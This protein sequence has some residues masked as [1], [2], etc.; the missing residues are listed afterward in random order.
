MADIQPRPIL[1]TGGGR[2]IGLALARH[3][4]AR[5]QPVIISYRTWYPAI[6]ALREAS[7]VCLHADFST[8]DS[9]LAFAEE[10]KAHAG[11]GLR[12]I[13]HNASGWMAEKP[14]VPLTTVLASMMQIHVNAPYLLNH[15]LESLLRGHG[16]AAS[17]IIH[18]TDYVVE[19]GSDKHIAYAASKAALDNM[20][21][22]F[23]RKLA[24][25][26]KVN[27]I[28]PSLILFNE[29]DDAEYRKQALD[30]SLMKIAPGEKEISDLIEYLFSSRYVTGRSFAVDGG[31][32]LR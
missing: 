21:R 19:R 7:A 15:A 16:H 3:F 32:H 10:V 28:A 1:I 27:A 26:I 29:G 8:D 24:P 18:I 14:G 25:E 9:I 11:S 31:R 5:Q 30:K 13:I 17:D 12:A 22:S 6:D 23:A 20:S 4:L 2:R